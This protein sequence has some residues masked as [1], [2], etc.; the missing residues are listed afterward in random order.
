[1]T[2]RDLLDRARNSTPPPTANRPHAGLD[3]PAGRETR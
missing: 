1:M 3:V 2:P